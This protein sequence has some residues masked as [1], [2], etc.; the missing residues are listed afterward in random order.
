MIDIILIIILFTEKTINDES[1]KLPDI[2]I[3]DDSK[4]IG[5]EI[6]KRAKTIATSSFINAECS[7]ENPI[8]HQVR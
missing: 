4:D 8:T 7:E 2:D 6:K 3:C 1:Y 5:F